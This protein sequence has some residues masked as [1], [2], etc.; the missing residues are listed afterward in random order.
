M[1]PFSFLQNP[2]RYTINLERALHDAAVKK[3][4]SQGYRFSEYVARL[5]QVDLRRKRGAARLARR[6]FQPSP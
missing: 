5:L 4:A 6:S 1:P 2:R 3:A